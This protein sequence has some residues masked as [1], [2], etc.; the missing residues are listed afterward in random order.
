M[1]N[2][3]IA[4][5]QTGAGPNS[6]PPG[7]AG[8]LAGQGEPVAYEAILAVVRAAWALVDNTGHHD[9]LPLAVNRDDWNDLSARLITLKTLI[10]PDELPA[11]PPHA[12]TLFWPAPRPA[13]D[14]AGLSESDLDTLDWISSELSAKGQTA[15]A[16]VVTKAAH[17]ALT[18]AAPRPEV[19]EEEIAQRLI[20]AID[21]NVSAV[22]SANSETWIDYAQT[23]EVIL[24]VFRDAD[25]GGKE[26]AR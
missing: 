13:G 21:Q 14:L 7:P 22:T 4:P 8:D 15:A 16:S 1:S 11:D 20:K 3:L 12:V 25:R 26:G 2:L 18:P 19:T 10:P 6:I 5:S 23:R 17:C 9:L 24:A